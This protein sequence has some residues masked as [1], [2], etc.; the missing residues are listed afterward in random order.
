MRP[1]TSTPEPASQK[2]S[3]PESAR[4]NRSQPSQLPK[5]RPIA[6]AGAVPLP[7]LEPWTAFG[8]LCEVEDRNGQN[9]VFTTHESELH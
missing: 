5:G 2:P 8:R 4:P 6:L 1:I 9:R 3:A 7:G